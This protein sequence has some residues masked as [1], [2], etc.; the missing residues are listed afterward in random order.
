MKTGKHPP[1]AAA[2]NRERELTEDLIA[3]AEHLLWRL[4]GTPV[5][6]RLLSSLYRLHKRIGDLI[7]NT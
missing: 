5:E 3:R 6:D 2:P 7:G 1:R 4:D